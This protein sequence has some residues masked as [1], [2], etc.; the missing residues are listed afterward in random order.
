[1]TGSRARLRVIGSGDFNCDV[2]AAPRCA[3][4][5]AEGGKPSGRALYFVKHS[6]KRNLKLSE[7]SHPDDGAAF[8]PIR[9]IRSKRP[10]RVLSNVKSLSGL[11]I[12]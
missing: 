11:Q 6:I 4:A 5:L 12:L 7:Q 2:N 3:A 8:G 1:M 10:H 9:R